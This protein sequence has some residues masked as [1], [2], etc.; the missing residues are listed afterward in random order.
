MSRLGGGAESPANETEEAPGLGSVVERLCG[1]G[2]LARWRG[3]DEGRGPLLPYSGC[4]A[5]AGVRQVDAGSP[6]AWGCGL[7]SVVANWRSNMKAEGAYH[8]DMRWRGGRRGGAD[9]V[10]S[11]TTEAGRRFKERLCGRVCAGEVETLSRV[12]EASDGR[13]GGRS[14][15]WWSGGVVEVPRGIAE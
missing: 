4:G 13:L 3:S 2:E 8:I 6:S 10:L 15:A 11:W 5:G 1:G 12:I 9:D 14:S 7:A